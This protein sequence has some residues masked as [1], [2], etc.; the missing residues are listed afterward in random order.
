MSR[1][2]IESRGIVRYLRHDS[3]APRDPAGYVAVTFILRFFRLTRTDLD[4]IVDSQQNAQKSRLSYSSD[5]NYIRASSGHTTSDVDTRLVATDIISEPTDIYCVHGTTRLAFEKIWKTGIN[6][7]TRHYIHFAD[8]PSKI[9]PG[10]EVLIQLA[11]SKYLR[12][13]LKLYRLQN[14]TIAAEG[15]KAGII[16][17]TFFKTVKFL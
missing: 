9:R 7:M 5:G 2:T 15:N 6:R 12:A 14:G 13:G 8:H 4:A 10:S 16:R 3:T 1:L 11:V 17:Q